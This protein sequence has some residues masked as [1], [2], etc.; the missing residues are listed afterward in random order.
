MWSFCSCL[1]SIQYLPDTILDAAETAVNKTFADGD[2]PVNPL[3]C[4]STLVTSAVEYKVI[5]LDH[6]FFSSGLFQ[7]EINL[8]LRR[9]IHTKF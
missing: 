3:A 6:H 1:L 7:N 5:P 9:V 4:E 2:T 8:Y